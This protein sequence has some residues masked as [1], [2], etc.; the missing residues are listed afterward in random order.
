MEAIKK[1]INYCYL[2]ITLLALSS[3]AYDKAEPKPRFPDSIIYMNIQDTTM[4][5]IR[6]GVGIYFYPSDSSASFSFDADGDGINDL[7]IGLGH[8]IQ[9]TGYPGVHDVYY[10]IGAGVFN[11]SNGISFS[12]N[13]G[14]NSNAT[15]FPHGGLINNSLS[16]NTQASMY[17]RGQYYGNYVS[18][19]SLS[20][21]QYIGF[22]IYKNS[23]YYYGWVL[24]SMN[25]FFSLTVKEWA[26]NNTAGNPIH[27]GQTQ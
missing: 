21:D 6:G 12:G 14:W 3:C 26:I 11:S 25:D 23:S 7:S 13:S 27:A 16:Y 17:L 22:R 5:T 20:G 2:L 10:S 8:S 18:Y 24:V 4:T 19:G 15:I 9:P 1:Q